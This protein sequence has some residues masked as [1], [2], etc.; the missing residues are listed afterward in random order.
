M[1]W[2]GEGGGGGGGRGG[3]GGEVDVSGGSLLCCNDLCVQWEAEGVV[4][5]FKSLLGEG[6]SQGCLPGSGSRVSENTQ[7]QRLDI[8]NKGTVF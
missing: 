3:G 7:D 5:R 4:L 1:L 2:G 6:C 8:P